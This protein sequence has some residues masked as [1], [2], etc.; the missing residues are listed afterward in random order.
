MVNWAE[1]EW[2][3][4][5]VVW[6]RKGLRLHDNPALIKAIE[7]ANAKSIPLAPLFVIDPRFAHSS[8][9]GGNRYHFLLESLSDLD[10]N[11]KNKYQSKLIVLKGNPVQVFSDMF[12]SNHPFKVVKVFLESDTEPYALKRDSEIQK[13]AESF[14]VEIESFCSHTIFNPIQTIEENG[15]KPPLTY[16]SFEGLVYS[17]LRK[18]KALPSPDPSHFPSL[19]VISVS[20][21]IPTLEEMGYSDSDV[22]FSRALHGGETIALETMEEYLKDHKKVVSFEKPQ[23][24]PAEWLPASTT[25]LSPYLKFGCLSPRLFAVRLLE[26]EKANPKHS[27]P[28][29][30]LI[31]QLLWREFFYTVA[32]GTPN[33]DSMELNPICR[34]FSWVSDDEELISKWELAQTGYPWIDALMTQL[35]T[36]GWMHHL[37]RHSVACFLTRGDLYCSWE[38]GAK[39]FDRLLLDADWSLN[40]S[41]WL[42]LSASAFFHQYF[43]VYS[44]IAFPKKYDPSGK[45][46]RKF[47]PQLSK[48]PDKFIYEPWKAPLKIQKECGCIIG[49]DYPLPIVDHALVSKQNISKHKLAYD[50]SDAPPSKKAK[51]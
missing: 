33:Y 17:K 49:K 4:S 2:M 34:K 50:N 7:H 25:C 15:G 40:I 37:G 35:K 27:K 21:E 45:L 23:T 14:F 12:Q 10:R 19:P 8:F 9:V 6:F 5:V 47:L 18:I 41:N 48:F 22:N 44:P 16:K 36:E 30:S 32:F 1:R 29:V 20:H 26:I 24:S 3:E 28:P 46:V 51:K 42:W 39:V 13:L 38:K 11:L 43:R 31:G